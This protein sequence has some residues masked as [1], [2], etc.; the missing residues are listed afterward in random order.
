M[1]KQIRLHEQYPNGRDIPHS[2]TGKELL[3]AYTRYGA[4]GVPGGE[5]GMMLYECR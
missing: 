2:W 4:Q 1:W 5:G 3:A